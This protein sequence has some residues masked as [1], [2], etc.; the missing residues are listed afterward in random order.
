[1]RIR[2][3]GYISPAM[4]MNNYFACFFIGWKYPFCGGTIGINITYGY[5][6]W[7]AH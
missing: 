3:A 4:K 2:S 7:D 5:I 1:M 6:F